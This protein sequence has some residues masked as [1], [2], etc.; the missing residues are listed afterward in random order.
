VI[1]PILITVRHG[2]VEEVANI[3][4]G[5]RVLVRDYDVEDAAMCSFDGEFQKD[6]AGEECIDTWYGATKTA[7]GERGYL[8]GLP[9]EDVLGEDP[10]WDQRWTLAD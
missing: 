6:A 3:P 4:A 5:V 8:L 1:P 9:I 7:S 10:D 2:V